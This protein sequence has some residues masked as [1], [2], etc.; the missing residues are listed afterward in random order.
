MKALSAIDIVRIWELGLAQNPADRAMT[1][2]APA[3]LE[4]KREE[5]AS[6][7]L[8]QMNTRLLSVR[9]GLFGPGINCYAECPRCGEGLEFTVSIPALKGEYTV[10]PSEQEYELSV[11]GYS[12]RFRLLNNLDLKAAMGNSNRE[13][14]RRLL[15]ERCVLESRKDN[16][17][18]PADRLPDA[19]ITTLAE[20]LSECDPQAEL[21]ID[22]E[23]PA[24]KNIWQTEFDVAGF[25][26]KELSAWARRLLGE[27]HV[28]ASAY[29]WREAEI[30]AMSARRRHYYLELINA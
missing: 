10:E 11:E 9:E 6:L 28:I 14:T 17:E 12:L 19:V 1:M 24:C 26:W 3:F 30:L 25:L 21:L 16:E 2:L 7:S 22:L 27:V 18:I 4:M 13:A 15:F 29:G 23:C 5:I 20:R 8:G